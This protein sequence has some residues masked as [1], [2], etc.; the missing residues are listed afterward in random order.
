[1][2]WVHIEKAKDKDRLDIENNIDVTAGTT[3]TWFDG[4]KHTDAYLRFRFEEPEGSASLTG[5]ILFPERGDAHFDGTLD[6]LK[7][8][9]LAASTTYVVLRDARFSFARW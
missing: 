5:C 4:S 2:D 6:D 3:T 9:C 7:S 1:M 8:L